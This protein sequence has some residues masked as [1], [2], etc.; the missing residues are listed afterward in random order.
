MK[1]LRMVIVCAAAL[2]ALCCAAV[3]PLREYIRLPQDMGLMYKDISPVTADEYKIKT[4]Y[5]PAQSMQEADS[6]GGRAVYR[7][8][9]PEY[10]VRPTIIF[11]NGDD[12]NMSHAPLHFAKIF[13]C[14]YGFNVVTF[15]WR[16]FGRSTKFPM[17]SNYICHTEMLEDYRAVIEAVLEQPETDKFHV[18]VIGN[19]T[20]GC[21]SMMAIQRSGRIAAFVGRGIPTDLREA[22]RQMVMY[23]GRDSASLRMPADFP[24]DE[25]PVKIA[26]QFYVPSLFIVGDRDTHTPMWMSRAIMDKMPEGVEKKLL[27]IENA[28]HGASAAPEVVAEDK[29][30]TATVEF[31]RAVGF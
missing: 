22:A 28:G 27:V 19:S 31:L 6:I 9:R 3:N 14:V 15:D 16:G 13:A 1:G 5:I 23:A 8:Y 12:A 18:A 2:S 17:N 20:G 10:G 11:C 24:M 7:P 26:P 4:W 25:M 30:V 21:L 29:V